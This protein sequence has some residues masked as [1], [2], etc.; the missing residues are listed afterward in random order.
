MDE[1]GERIIA[2]ALEGSTVAPGP[3]FPLAKFSSALYILLGYL[4]FVLIGSLVPH[5]SL[6]LYHL[7]FGYNLTQ[8]MVCS[9]MCIEAVMIAVRNNYSL[10][11]NSYTNPSPLADLLWFFYLSKILDF[12][13]TFFIILGNKWNQ[14]SFLHVYHHSTIF[15]I[16]WL[17][18]QTNYGGDV[19]LTIVLNGTIHAIMYTY[20]FVS[21]HTSDIWWKKYLTTAQLIQFNSMN[22]QAIYL[23]CTSC[24]DSPPRV[25]KFY[26]AYIASL[27]ALFLHFYIHSYTKKKTP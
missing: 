26:L 14:L 8:M 5:P 15:L 25:T 17:N 21:M 19:Y 3:D 2:F 27:F 18:L 16:Y 4:S 20:Y 12:C 22:A 6:K 23:L 10:V 9:Y 24:S 11:C 1:I 7:R 13:D